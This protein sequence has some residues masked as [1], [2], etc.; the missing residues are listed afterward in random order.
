M[1]SPLESVSQVQFLVKPIVRTK[2]NTTKLKNSCGP[3]TVKNQ[4]RKFSFDSGGEVHVFA[5]RAPR[6]RS[7]YHYGM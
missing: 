3:K 7:F 1:R 2:H 6:G 5:L 4:P